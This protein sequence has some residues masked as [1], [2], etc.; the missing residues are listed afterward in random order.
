MNSARSSPGVSASTS[1]IITLVAT[2]LAAVWKANEK[3][4]AICVGA[5]A[6]KICERSAVTRQSVEN[7]KF[8]I[9]SSVIEVP[10]DPDTPIETPLPQFT[11]NADEGA[12]T[13]RLK[14]MVMF[15]A[16]SRLA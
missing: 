10:G 9:G 4:D 5:C 14:L 13:L 16:G 7:G 2:G 15:A 6:A 11:E 8:A 3:S 1:L 12:V